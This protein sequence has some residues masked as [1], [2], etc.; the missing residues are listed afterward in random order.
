MQAAGL[1]PYTNTKTWPGVKHKRAAMTNSASNTVVNTSLTNSAKSN[2]GD[3]IEY[4][5]F[6]SCLSPY[7][8]TVQNLEHKRAV[9]KGSPTEKKAIL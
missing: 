5:L 4:I 8:N 6:G 9:T 2:L 1:S 7:T 3:T